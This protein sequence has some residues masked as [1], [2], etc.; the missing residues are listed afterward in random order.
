MQVAIGIYIAADKL[1]GTVIRN[2]RKTIDLAPVEISPFIK[3]FIGQKPSQKTR[4]MMDS[5][6]ST[7]LQLQ[8]KQFVINGEPIEYALARGF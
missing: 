4:R 2:N 8:N 7:A 3:S 5:L 6:N 1:H